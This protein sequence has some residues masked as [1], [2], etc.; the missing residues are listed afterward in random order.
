MNCIE[1]VKMWIIYWK[2]TSKFSVV[3]VTYLTF[4]KCNVLPICSSSSIYK[5][6]MNDTLSLK[7]ILLDGIKGGFT[8][9]SSFYDKVFHENG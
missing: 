2:Y 4:L 3:E 5:G 9:Q 7:I 6:Q 8:A 1:L